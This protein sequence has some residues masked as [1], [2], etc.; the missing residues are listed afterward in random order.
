MKQPEAYVLGQSDRAA[1]RLEM[2]DAQFGDASEKLLDAL[3][4][5]PND[6]VVEVGCG[7]GSFSKRI[8]RR[9]GAGGALVGVD[10]SEP[11]LTHARGALA[12]FGPARFEAVLGD[13]SQ[14]GEWLDDA[15]VVVGRAVLHHLPMVELFL[16]RLRARLK[17]GTRVGFLEPDFRTRLAR[18]AHLEATGR[19]ELA[20]LGIWAT[21]I[22]QLYQLRRLSPEI[23]PTLAPALRTAGFQRVREQS[24][25]GPWTAEVIENLIMFY[26][27]VR[28]TLQQLGILSG[29][30]I[31]RQQQLLGALPLQTLPPV[32]GLCWAASVT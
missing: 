12:N 22:S 11:L 28:D 32:W 10:S 15:D 20:P 16:G 5:R 19:P 3:A 21:A 13:I 26:D 1:R 17:P 24:S 18:L 8:L 25:E 9:L 31:E 6:H 23:G 30:E 2:Q 14:L 27:E 4:I 29:Q 7:P